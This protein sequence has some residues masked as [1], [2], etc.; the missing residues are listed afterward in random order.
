M[1]SGQVPWN[2][3]FLRPTSNRDIVIRMLNNLKSVFVGRS[4]AVRLAIVMDMRGA[5]PELAELEA[6]EITSSAAVFN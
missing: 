3:Q 5:V 1:T 2:E 6:A 4:D